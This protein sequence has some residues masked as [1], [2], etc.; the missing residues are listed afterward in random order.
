MGF[1]TKNYCAGDGQQQF[2]RLIN[3]STQGEVEMQIT[4]SC[5][6]VKQG[7]ESHGTRNQE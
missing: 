4:P 6:T 1:K 5:E 2:N 3:K 7:H